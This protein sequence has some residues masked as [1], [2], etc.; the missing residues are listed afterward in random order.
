MNHLALGQFSVSLAV[1]DIQKSLSFYEAL[2]FEVVEGGHMNKGFPDGEKTKW[3]ILK[4]DEAVIGLFEGM[5]PENILTFNPT[6]VRSIQ[7]ELK[8]RGLTLLQEADTNTSGPGHA[9]VVDPDGNQI[10]IDQH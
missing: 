10:L 5:F 4:S 6:D 8:A 9:V 7:K 3:R 2:G 1:A